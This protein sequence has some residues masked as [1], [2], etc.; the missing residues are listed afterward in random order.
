MSGFRTILYI[1]CICASFSAFG[2]DAFISHI[3]QHRANLP[4][5][6][7]LRLDSLAY[8][9]SGTTEVGL[10]I[11]ALIHLGIVQ[12]YNNRLSES[13][14]ALFNAIKLAKQEDLGYTL[15]KAYRLLGVSLVY[16]NRPEAL[17]YF[18]RAKQLAIQYQD[19]VNLNKSYISLALYHLDHDEIQQA[20]AYL[21][22]VSVSESTRYI[23]GYKLFCYARTLFDEGEY[24]ASI[25]PFEK[26]LVFFRNRGD[27]LNSLRTRVNLFLIQHHQGNNIAA[28]DGLEITL[29]Q[30]LQLDEKDL[31]AQ[32]AR[33]LHIVHSKEGNRALADSFYRL[34]HQQKTKVIESSYMD[35][36]TTAEL[37]YENQLVQA[38]LKQAQ[39]EEEY[40]R[41]RFTALAIISVL[42]ILL[43]LAIFVGQA[44]A[45]RAKERLISVTLDNQ[46]LQ[47]RQLSNEL[48][49]G[50]IDILFSLNLIKQGE[51]FDK[52]LARMRERSVALAT[53]IYPVNLTSNLGLP[54]AL[55]EL[56]MS[57]QSENE[58]RLRFNDSRDE[59][60]ASSEL[61]QL[62]YYLISET[63][64]SLL[65]DE[66]MEELQAI[67]SENNKNVELKLLRIPYFENNRIQLPIESIKLQVNLLRGSISSGDNFVLIKLPSV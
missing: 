31:I 50:V 53:K 40:S 39:L 9:R 37:A 57:L 30:A 36:L 14:F 1:I 43:L 6:E 4:Q 66:Q 5:A 15:P 19:S 58:L 26:A 46:R 67:V 45:R 33:S 34:S 18:H 8:N 62:L 10:Q 17:E 61:D 32:I 35:P 60:M 38:E 27:S 12:R 56:A 54:S 2:K 41:D 63:A 29:D 13:V 28:L 48:H 44:K 51:D 3:Y 55:E 64:Y 25:E 11:E 21:D 52:A 22:S 24:E 47:R 7:L 20:N 59:H 23:E 49:R 42:V 65:E 16:A